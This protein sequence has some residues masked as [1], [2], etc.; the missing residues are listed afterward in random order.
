M[1]S[2]ALW[3]GRFG[4]NDGIIGKVFIVN[5]VRLTIIGVAS[6]GF[7]GT[8]LNVVDVWTPLGSAALGSL[9]TRA[10]GWERY[11][12]VVLRRTSAASD[13]T[14]AA[15]ATAVMRQARAGEAGDDS[16]SQVLTGSI[17]ESRGPGKEQNEVL[18]AERLGAVA[19]IVLL[20]ACSNVMNLLLARAVS[21]RREIALR[22]ALGISR[23][24]LIW[25]LSAPNVVLALVGGAAA[26]ASGLVT[27][28]AL[29]AQ[30]APDVHFAES[31][32]D[33][34]VIVF[35]LAGALAAGLVSAIVPALRAS[36]PDVTTFLKSGAQSGLVQRSGLRTGPLI[37]QTALSVVLLVGAALFVRSLW[38]IDSVRIGYDADRLFSATPLGIGEPDSATMAAAVE[39]VGRVPGVMGV[40]MAT[41]APM[42]GGVLGAK[43]YTLTDSVDDRVPVQ[44]KP[45]FMNVSLNY[46]EL[47]GMR[48]LRGNG[49]APEPTLSAVVNE[50]M[51]R[52]YWPGGHAIGQ[53]IW[54]DSRRNPC[55]V[56]VG[57]AE[58]ARRRAVV[59][60][61]HAHY[62]LPLTHP[63]FKG[64]GGYTLIVRTEPHQESDAMAATRQVLRALFPAARP[65]LER[66]NDTI[67]PGYRPFRLGAKL[68]TTFGLLAF[69]V[70]I[71]GVYS[72]VSYTVQQRTHEFGVRIALGARGRDVLVNILPTTLRPVAFGIGAGV[73]IS[74]RRE[75]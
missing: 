19:I 33:W 34:R 21:Q 36:N 12:G 11:L 41:Y 42:S 69:L 24:R 6:P 10:R 64:A 39:R 32:F 58:D 18:I 53:C 47:T 22:V 4:G 57:I 38:K 46:F 67:A 8:D 2:D 71:V 17:I 3:R 25:L 5:G 9:G 52:Q 50:T 48:I 26:G 20:I 28:A 37:V 70:A 62:F 7:R 75:A 44:D 43:L 27:G 60:K 61:S 55:Y 30:L 49:F 63:P 14:I 35:T 31:P 65:R 16:L 73:L 66:M 40:A 15:R 1:I 72:A 74:S 59:E 45:T 51:A 56:V 23:S 13:A 29:R 68:F 54:L